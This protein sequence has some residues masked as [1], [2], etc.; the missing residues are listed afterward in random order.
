MAMRQTDDPYPL[1][2]KFTRQ[3]VTL[4]C[5]NAKFYGRTAYSIDPG[6]LGNETAK[7][8]MEAAKAIFLET[9]SGPSSLL[10]VIQRLQTW[11]YEGKVAHEKIVAV[12][13][14]FDEAIDAGLLPVP[15]VENEIL[16]ILK[17]R[18]SKKVALT[19]SDAYGKD[20]GFD[21]VLELINLK[22]ALGVNDRNMGIRLG[23]ASF[24]ALDALRQ[25]VRLPTGV[26]ELDSFLDGGCPRGSLL[27]WMAGP[28]G[29][30]SQALSH[31]AAHTIRHGMH[32][33][34][35]T[36]E[37]PEA[38]VAARVKANLTGIPINEILQGG[39]AKAKQLLERIPN[40]GAFTVKEFTPHATTIND[41]TDWVKEVE[42]DVGSPVDKL[43]IDY[44]DKC[45]SFQSKGQ[46]GND[47]VGMRE[48]YEKARIWAHENKKVVESASQSQGRSE[49][50]TKKIDMEHTADSMHKVRVADIVVTN[51]YD[52]D[53]GD[54]GFWVA[55]HRTGKSRQMIGP[56]PVDFSCGQIAPVAREF[57]SFE[58]YLERV[59]GDPMKVKV[60]EDI[61]INEARSALKGDE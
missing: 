1:D 51:N 24:K 3:L 53:S 7:L 13:D 14:Y 52:E 34:Y 8:A 54:M 45:V 61:M 23:A 50:K 2:P 17:K 35:A 9:K 5:A 32:A 10:T 44:L 4:A 48:V 57:I 37:L 43:S 16:Q 18:I 59:N 12:S 20:L 31:S 28:G 60:V 22:T 15:E 27:V 39:E 26:M 29:G 21:K 25:L 47:Y 30:K 46:A 19:A 11:R 58:E 40:L 36:L 38:V 56:L 55:K 42:D 49:K 41:I 6:L 33:C